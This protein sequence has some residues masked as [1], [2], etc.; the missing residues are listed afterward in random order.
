MS[1]TVKRV[2]KTA[3]RV[4]TVTTI[5]LVA[6]LGAEAEAHTRIINGK[7]R[8]C[9][10]CDD[11]A[12]V[13][14]VPANFFGVAELIVRTERTVTIVC[15][16]EDV[17]VKTELTL[18][19]ETPFRG[20]EKGEADVPVRL[21]VSGQING[22]CVDEK[23]NPTPS[24]DMEIPAMNLEYNAYECSADPRDSECRSRVLVSSLRLK[25]R[26]PKGEDP[27]IPDTPYECKNPRDEHVF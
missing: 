9:S 13:E 22:F 10:I 17:Q 11:D 6:M 15:P 2:S 7:P 21:V 14:E 18:V 26:I 23:G 4:M 5:G 24:V 20:P 8:V 3:K 27:G 19:G 12:R 1:K 16:R 25:C